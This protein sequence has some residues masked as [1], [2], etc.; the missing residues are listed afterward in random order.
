MQATVTTIGVSGFHTFPVTVICAIV[1]GISSL[2]VIGISN[3]N[4]ALVKAH[5]KDAFAALGL[6]LPAKR[7]EVRLHSSLP[8]TVGPWLDLPIT[9]SIFGALGI[10][11][12]ELLLDFVVVGGIGANGRLVATVGTTMAAVFALS[13]DQTLICPREAEGCCDMLPAQSVI[14]APD[15]ISLVGHLTGRHLLPAPRRSDGV[16][17]ADDGLWSHIADFEAELLQRFR[18]GN[19]L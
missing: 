9:L 3:Q 15:L 19:R 2:S 14:A 17:R 18:L 6:A 12:I 8:E 1:P 10:V 7:I 16:K 13:I 5:I 11:D 4:R